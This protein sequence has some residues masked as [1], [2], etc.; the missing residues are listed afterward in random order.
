LSALF[1]IVESTSRKYRKQT[2]YTCYFTQ[3]S[4][5]KRFLKPIKEGIVFRLYIL[6]ENKNSNTILAIPTNAL[7]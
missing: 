1:G 6:K 5:K 2:L 7:K 3:F 4:F